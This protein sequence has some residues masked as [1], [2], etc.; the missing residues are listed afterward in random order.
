M[1]KLST[2]RSGGRKAPRCAH[3]TKGGLFPRCAGFNYFRVVGRL[4]STWF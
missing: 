1:A 3:A 2:K 4:G